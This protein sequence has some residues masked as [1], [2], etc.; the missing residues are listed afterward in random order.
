MSKLST[1]RVHPFRNAGLCMVIGAVSF[2]FASTVL[3]QGPNDL[4]PAIFWFLIPLIMLVTA[5][6]LLVL[7]IARRSRQ[8]PA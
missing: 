6:T 1:L 8:A 7:G 2:V 4:W 3:P 5:I